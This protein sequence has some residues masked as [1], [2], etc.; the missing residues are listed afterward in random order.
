MMTK[1]LFPFSGF[2]W[3]K[4]IYCSGFVYLTTV[5][6]CFLGIFFRIAC[7]IPVLPYSQNLTSI[8]NKMYFRHS[9]NVSKDY[10]F[11]SQAREQFQR[12]ALRGGSTC[13]QQVWSTWCLF[14][15][16]SWRRMILKI[17][18]FSVTPYVSYYQSKL[19][20]THC[21]AFY[22][23]NLLKQQAATTL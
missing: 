2:V 10:L 22:K 19:F 9:L 18:S 17:D 16:P 7:Y 5:Y 3:K 11:P 21:S 23:G 14:K 6:K 12:R 20:Q 8:G 15:I 1:Y 13:C 4:Y